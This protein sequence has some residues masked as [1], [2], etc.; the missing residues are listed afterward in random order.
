MLHVSPFFSKF[1][2]KQ[3]TNHFYLARFKRTMNLTKAFTLSITLSGLAFISGCQRE[4]EILDSSLHEAVFH[5]GWDSETRTVLQED[6]NVWWSPGDEISLFVNDGQGGYKLTST[7][8][9]PSSLVDFEG[10]IGGGAENSTYVALYP[11]NSDSW[12][13]GD[14]LITFI[15][16]NQVAKEGSFAEGSFPSYA[17]SQTD[18]LYFK[19]IAS[20]IKFSVAHD[21]IRKIVISRYSDMSAGQIGGEVGVSHL[22]KDNPVITSWGSWDPLTLEAP[23]GGCFKTGSY[24]YASVIPNTHNLGLW[25]EY[26]TDDNQVA[27]VLMPGPVEFHRGVFKRFYEKDKDLV[28]H[29]HYDKKALLYPESLLPKGIDKSLITNVSF[30]VNS[31]KTTDTVISAKANNYCPVYFELD[32]TTANYYTPAEIYEIGWADRMFFAW[33]SLKEL[34]LSNIVMSDEAIVINGMFADCESLK[35]I[36]FGYFSTEHVTDMQGVFSNCWSLE[37]LDLSGFRTSKV[38]DMSKMFSGCSSLKTL[39]LSSFDT[40]NVEDMNNMFGGFSVYPLDMPTFK[41]GITGCSSLESLDLHTF[42][43]SKV[44][45]MQG[46]FSYCYNL[47]TVNLSGW[48]TSCVEGLGGMFNGCVSLESVDLSSFDTRN[49]T[50]M[51][52]MF[53]CCYNLK[54]LDL[55]NFDT[56]RVTSMQDMFFECES[57]QTLDI[58]HFDSSNLTDAFAF[59][60]GTRRLK[61]LDL[62]TFDISTIDILEEAFNGLAQRSKNVAIRCIASTKQTIESLANSFFNPDYVTW[63]GQDETF[64]EL[65]PDIINPDMYYSSDYS[66]DKQVQALQ[67][68]TTGKGV[69][70]VIMG[71]S[72]SDRLIADGTYERDMRE[73][74]EALFSVEPMKSFRHLFNVYMVYAVSQNEVYNGSTVFRVQPV[75]G[76]NYTGGDSSIVNTYTK[77]AVPNKPFSDIATIIV[78]HDT[79]AF[80]GNGGTTWVSYSGSA[81]QY[82][83]YGPALWSIAYVGR[84]D[85]DSYPYITVHEFGHLF[86]KLADEYVL[87]DS[88]VENLDEYLCQHLGIYKNI[89]YTGNP[90]TVKWSKFLK[91]SRYS[92]ENL[93]VYEGGLLYSR[94][95]WRPSEESIMRSSWTQFNAP[96]REATYNRIHKLAYGDS[97]QYDYETFVQQDLKNIHPATRSS[98]VEVPSPARFNWKHGFWIE[99]STLEDGSKSISLIMN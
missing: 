61:Q 22:D 80:V 20:G 76:S 17:V 95:V 63:V 35:S 94:G 25:I 72:Y 10:Q 79:N 47:K 38:K 41:V 93:G 48:D 46:M 84:W 18:H 91:D 52:M 75:S 4:K 21:N 64:P 19:N 88:E 43:T 36:K 5:A 67:T 24:Y 9:E 89:D 11:Y 57:L 73:A 31:D 37:S 49:V 30:I 12:L 15:P 58:S 74:I 27:K 3:I 6:G 98:Y 87:Y 65:P 66:M 7:N 29:P 33:T 71:D 90:E 70:I 26:I 32:G 51:G 83:D 56:S 16:L 23:D 78:G 69:D 85:G 40:S 96:S 82:Y 39:D 44:K 13:W 97:W 81:D 68:A 28:F 42:N 53:E 59:L 86:A 77:R 54:S 62:G 1:V 99:K 60:E 92:S 34:D 2:S 50:W 8:T 14:E 55:S 45:Y